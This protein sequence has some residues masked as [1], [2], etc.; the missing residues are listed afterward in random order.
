MFG[1]SELG[2][3]C[4]QSVCEGTSSARSGGGGGPRGMKRGRGRHDMEPGVFCVD[5][6]NLLEV[7]VIEIFNT[8]KPVTE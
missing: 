5:M 7:C 4:S 3:V 8:H 1:V 6:L 2:K